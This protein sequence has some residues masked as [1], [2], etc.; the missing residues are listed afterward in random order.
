MTLNSKITANEVS[1]AIA[2]CKPDKSC[3]PDNLLNEVLKCTHD[4]TLVFIV[5]AFNTLFE[6]KFF[7]LEW[8]HA[9]IL[10][11]YKKGDVNLCDNY[12]P[13]WLTSLFSKLYTNILNNRINV[14]SSLNNI[15]PEKQAGF[16]SNYS[17]IDHI[18]TLYAMISSQ[19]S[20]NKKLYVCFVD[21]R[22]AFD[23][24]QREALFKILE[25]RGFDGNFLSAIKA[26]YS[27]VNA[28]IYVDGC[29]SESFT[30]PLGL[31]QGCLLSPNLFSLFMTEI[32]IEIN[33][34]GLDGITF[35]NNFDTIFHLLFADDIILVSDSVIGLQNQINILES[36]S[37]RLGLSINEN[38]T[39]IV[40]FR[41][42]GYIAKNEKWYYGNKCLKIVILWY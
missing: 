35:I 38:K 14:F 23:S 41:K 34:R 27:K 36:Q 13:I 18:F 33:K 40:I 37:I 11:I 39:E 15:I 12:R 26:I 19:F 9:N 10:P 3:G 30:C 7:P 17:T 20:K 6:N 5:N 16:R 4:D 29:Q 42:G 22:K 1:C 31:K 21:Y 28:S 8:T 2:K 32:S 25:A 24:V